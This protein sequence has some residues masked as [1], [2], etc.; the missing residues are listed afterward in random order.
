MKPIFYC[1]ETYTVYT[2]LHHYLEGEETQRRSGNLSD[3][4]LLRPKRNPS[5]NYF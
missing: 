1:S 3:W 4:Y 2:L 5:R